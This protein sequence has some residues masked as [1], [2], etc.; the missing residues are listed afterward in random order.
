ME[1]QPLLPLATPQVDFVETR[2]CPAVGDNAK[3]SSGRLVDPPGS[4]TLHVL[5]RLMQR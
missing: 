3:V 2:I 1:Q 4:A 5:G